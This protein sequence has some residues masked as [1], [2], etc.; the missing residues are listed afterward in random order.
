MVTVQTCTIDEIEESGLADGYAEYS[1]PGMPKPNPQWDM[2]R[3]MEHAGVIKVFGAYKGQD[4]IGFMSLLTGMSQHYGVVVV[5][6]ES[7]FV[8]KK[9]RKSGAGIKLI[10]HA[11]D[12]ARA[13]KAAGVIYSA[14][15]GG[16]LFKLLQN[17]LPGYYTLFFKAIP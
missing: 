12:Y 10:R 9:Q 2:Y 5:T 8:D 6:V 17:R 14:P 16:E 11:E 13:T 4:L 15:T 1:M 3:S 7:F